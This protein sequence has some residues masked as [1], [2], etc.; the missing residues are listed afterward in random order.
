M[1]NSQLFPT[2]QNTPDQMNG[3]I[4]FVDNKTSQEHQYIATSED[5]KVPKEISNLTAGNDWYQKDLSHMTTNLMQKELNSTALTPTAR[6]ADINYAGSISHYSPGDTSDHGA[7]ADIKIYNKRKQMYISA[8]YGIKPSYQDILG[9]DPSHDE[10]QNVAGYR[11]EW[12]NVTRNNAIQ[13]ERTRIAYSDEA[14]NIIHD[15]VNRILGYD[16][17][18]DNNVRWAQSRLAN[19]ESMK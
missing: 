17:G 6:I 10:I 13:N 18:N 9:R 15:N 19:G 14:F 16:W 4:F 12:D 1:P 5:V 2:A 8:E 7:S 3:S 11:I